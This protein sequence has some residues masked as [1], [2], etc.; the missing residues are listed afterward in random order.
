MT[1]DY[2][3]PR[4]ERILGKLRA[5]GIPIENYQ[6]AIKHLKE[7]TVN[8]VYCIEVYREWYDIHK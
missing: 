4:F 1:T 2:L 3:T 8:P 5:D 6:L 7:H